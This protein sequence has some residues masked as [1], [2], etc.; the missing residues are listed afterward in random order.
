ML[1]AVA[2]IPASSALIIYFSGA[3]CLFKDIITGFFEV[4]AHVKIY[5]DHAYSEV[6]EQEYV[7]IWC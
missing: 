4:A 5:D 2:P 7:P 1:R 3:P 6:S